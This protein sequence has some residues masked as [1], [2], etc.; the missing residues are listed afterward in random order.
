MVEREMYNV[1]AT[2]YQYI[3]MLIIEEGKSMKQY[4]SH[5]IVTG[6][7]WE[8]YAQIQCLKTSFVHIHSQ[9][10]HMDEASTLHS[11]PAWMLISLIH[12]EAII[13]NNWW[14][15]R[16]GLGGGVCLWCLAPCWGPY[17]GAGTRGT[18]TLCWPG[19][20]WSWGH[21]YRLASKASKFWNCCN[22][23][24]R[25]LVFGYTRAGIYQSQRIK[26]IKNVFLSMKHTKIWMWHP[27]F[28]KIENSCKMWR[29]VFYSF[30]NRYVCGVHTA[31]PSMILNCKQ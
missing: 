31:L 17:C 9:Q 12:C 18:S 26:N 13:E 5:T 20:E 1:D 14:P 7:G 11:Q 6:D 3:N 22:I 24:D 16:G 23:G 10:Q 29:I 15:G 28:H 30:S 8:S 2:H 27:T 25:I 19:R 4:K 21:V